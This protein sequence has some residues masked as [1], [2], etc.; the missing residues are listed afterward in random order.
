MTTLEKTK[1]KGE[2]K[3]PSRAQYYNTED[4]MQRQRPVIRF[5]TQTQDEELTRIYT[6]NEDLKKDIQRGNPDILPTGAT[7][8]MLRQR[9]VPKKPFDD[10]AEISYKV[11]SKGKLLFSLYAIAVLSL[12]LVI[13]LNAV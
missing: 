6:D 3:M 10:E 9:E 11:N 13:V 1:N 5:S 8:K 12:I 4:Q 7:L 2:F